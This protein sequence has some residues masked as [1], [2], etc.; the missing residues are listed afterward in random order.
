MM[1]QLLIGDP[2]AAAPYLEL[3][4]DR[5]PWVRVYRVR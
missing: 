5:Y 3:V 2:A 1:V 4:E